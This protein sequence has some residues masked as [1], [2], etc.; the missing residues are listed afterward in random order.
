MKMC[1]ITHDHFEVNLLQSVDENVKQQTLP[2]SAAFAAAKR[3]CETPLWVLD[4]HCYS[5]QTL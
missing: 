3:E 2:V 5:G 4:A 1:W